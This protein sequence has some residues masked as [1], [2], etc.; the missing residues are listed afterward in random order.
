MTQQP[1]T[2]KS[3]SSLLVPTLIGVSLVAA[4]AL[5]LNMQ[6]GLNPGQG[7]YPGPSTPV[8][9]RAPTQVAESTS[10][11]APWKLT[12]EAQAIATAEATWTTSPESLRPADPSAPVPD[13]F[14]PV[15][16]LQRQTDTGRIV[17]AVNNAMVTEMLRIQP[18]NRWVA[19]SKEGVIIVWAGAQL[20]QTAA[21]G[22]FGGLSATG[23]GVIQVHRYNVDPH[24]VSNWET[25]GPDEVQTYLADGKVGGLV[26]VDERAGI[27]V[28]KAPDGSTLAFNVAS[29]KFETP[30]AVPEAARQVG[31]GVISESV[32][33]RLALTDG[34][35]INSWQTGPDQPE[36]A[37]F[38]GIVNGSESSDGGT[39]GVALAASTTVTDPAA[40]NLIEAP[41]EALG[42]MWVFDAYDQ[43][44]I[45]RDWQTGVFVFDV[46]ERRFLTNEEVAKWGGL[47]TGSLIP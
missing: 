8:D 17:D 44:V 32:P 12:A 39:P 33:E 43:K 19:V 9:G 5:F 13:G 1:A 40:L 10:G 37:L 14:G 28:L 23:Q 45:L 24:A 15:P 47:R 11:V 7:G 2:R 30:A 31:L 21:D 20:S 3:L 36:M 34:H 6:G 16:L 42:P 35:F 38:A 27:L 29:G 26:I 25:N 18:T 41:A 4:I 46:I 22:A